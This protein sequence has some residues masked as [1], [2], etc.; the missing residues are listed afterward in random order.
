MNTVLVGLLTMATFS[1]LL[2]ALH[3]Q[4]LTQTS[5]PSDSWSAIAGSADGGRV[6]AVSGDS[7]GAFWGGI[8]VST[9][10]GDSWALTTAPSN[11]WT[12]VAISADGK[13]IVAGAGN[14]SQ[15]PGPLIISTNGG[16]DW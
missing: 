5:A 9:N 1:A 6:V 4:D 13:A 7:F 10:S 3:G 2:P 16:D 15:G 12:T 11:T 14:P 8:F